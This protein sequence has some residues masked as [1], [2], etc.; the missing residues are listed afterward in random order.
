[1]RF[2]PLVICDH[3]GGLTRDVI[4]VNGKPYHIGCS[5]KVKE[6]SCT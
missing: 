3:C 2:K 4:Y 6:K 1:M 5:F